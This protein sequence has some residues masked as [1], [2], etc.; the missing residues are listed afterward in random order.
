MQCNPW[1]EIRKLPS[2]SRRLFVVGRRHRRKMSINGFDDEEIPCTTHRHELFCGGQPTHHVIEKFP[3]VEQLQPNRQKTETLC[4]QRFSTAFNFNAALSCSVDTLTLTHIRRKLEIWKFLVFRLKSLDDY[5]VSWC[6]HGHGTWTV[7]VLLIYNFIAF[8]RRSETQREWEMKRER[9]GKRDRGNVRCKQNR[10]WDGSAHTQTHRP[11]TA[12]VCVV[13]IILSQNIFPG[14]K[15]ALFVMNLTYVFVAEN[16]F[17]VERGYLYKSTLWR[18]MLNSLC[19]RLSIA[20][21][22]A[23]RFIFYL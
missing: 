13:I 7:C 2:N 16:E 20:T 22:P 8:Y 18:C 21:V 23:I 17:C 3:S 12:A 4:T 1:N 14:I 11:S 5:S 6:E 10:Q 19:K 15:T 9:Y